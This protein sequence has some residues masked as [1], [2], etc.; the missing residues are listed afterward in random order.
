M[1]HGHG[2]LALGLGPLA[3]HLAGDDEVEVVGLHPFLGL[4]H[5]EDLAIQAGVEIGAV[6]V[7]GVEHH[8]FVFFHDIDDVQLDAQLLG[9][10]QGIVALGFFLVLLADGVGMP[11]HAETREEIDAFHINALFL[12]DAHGQKGI[13]AAGNQGYCF[14]LHDRLGSSAPEGRKVIIAGKPGSILSG[15]FLGFFPSSMIGGYILR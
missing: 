2:V 4:F 3:H 1:H 8:V 6:A 14:A 15:I 9:A 13:Q 10:P 11:L 5:H 7:F 12:H